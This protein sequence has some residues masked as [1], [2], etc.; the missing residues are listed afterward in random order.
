[1]NAPANTDPRTGDGPAAQEPTIDGKYLVVVGVLLVA[2]IATLGVLWVRERRTRVA[3]QQQVYTL[4]DQ[5]RQAREQNT[6]LQTI[7]NAVNLGI[8][9]V[10]AEEIELVTVEHPVTTQRVQA[11]RISGQA[12]ARVG[13]FQPGDVILVA[14]AEGDPPG[15][16]APPGEDP[17]VAPAPAEGS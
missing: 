2:I 4:Q 5:L 11:V 9:P 1:V 16:P 3:L 15:E 14:P 12:A 13:P 17:V 6:M 7:R 10:T 8:E